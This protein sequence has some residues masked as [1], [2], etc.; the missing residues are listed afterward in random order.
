MEKFKKIRKIFDNITELGYVVSFTSVMFYDQYDNTNRI[1]NWLSASGALDR[2]RHITGIFAMVMFAVFCATLIIVGTVMHATSFFYTCTWSLFCVGNG[3][4]L[5]WFLFADSYMMDDSIADV[6]RVQ[7]NAGSRE[8]ADFI[9]NYMHMRMKNDEAKLSPDHALRILNSYIDETILSD[10]KSAELVARPK[11]I[12]DCIQI[13]RRDI[14]NEF[15][16]THVQILFSL[17]VS[18]LLSIKNMQ[19][20][21]VHIGRIIFENAGFIYILKKLFPY[22]SKDATNQLQKIGVSAESI[23]TY[24]ES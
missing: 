7:L 16:E 6:K 23:E 3:L 20:Q 9:E 10:K 5:V 18:R 24:F 1:K 22:L 17:F 12:N 8:F 11:L 21:G 14:E 2:N 13:I 19:G 15:T 4:I